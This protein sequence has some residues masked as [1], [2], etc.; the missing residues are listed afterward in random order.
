MFATLFNISGISTLFVH[1][2]NGR[3]HDAPVTDVTIVLTLG[4]RLVFPFLRLPFHPKQLQL[5]P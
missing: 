1:V 4:V 2:D 5:L 3:T